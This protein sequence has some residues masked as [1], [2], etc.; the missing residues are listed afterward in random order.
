VITLALVIHECDPLIVVAV[1]EQRSSRESCSVV[2]SVEIRREVMPKDMRDGNE[3]DNKEERQGGLPISTCSSSPVTKEVRQFELEDT[4]ATAPS[5]LLSPR[6]LTLAC[7]CD[8]VSDP[9][10]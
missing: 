3:N 4:I 1:F 10:G 9:V 7:C 5:N 6:N 2:D 8:T